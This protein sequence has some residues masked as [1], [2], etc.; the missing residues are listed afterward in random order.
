MALAHLLDPRY[1]GLSEKGTRGAR[2][3]SRSHE[4]L[5]FTRPQLPS[6]TPHYDDDATLTDTEDSMTTVRTKRSKSQVV[7]IY[8]S[9]VQC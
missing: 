7:P 6:G 2:A 4:E 5:G 9:R 3:R 1:A 8:T